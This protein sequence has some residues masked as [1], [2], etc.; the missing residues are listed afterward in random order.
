VNNKEPLISIVSTVYKSKSYLNEFLSTCI[1]ALNNIACA[2]YEIIFVN[3][4]SP[5]DS[6]EYLIEKKKEIPKIQILDL[7]RN[8]GHH[9]AAVAGL[10]HS[11]GKYV[12]L[13][14]CDLEVSP[15]I[16]VRFYH[17]LNSE[18]VDVVYGYQVERKGRYLERFFGG[19]FWK[20][21]KY[22]S[23]ID[24]PEN[25][26]TERLMTR[27]YVEQL[28]RLGDRNLFLGGMMYWTGFNQIG[29]AVSKGLRK[30]KSTYTAIKRLRLLIEAITS[31]T[32][33]PLKLLFYFGSIVTAISFSWG[34]FLAISK[35]L[36]PENYLS[37]YVSLILV[38]SFFSGIIEM[39]LGLLGLYLGK[40]FKQVQS[41]PLFIVKDIY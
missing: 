34:A 40:I 27:R 5:D 15:E 32:S 26:V 19:I 24:I 16:L 17:L 36:N 9:Y 2:D 10:H 37:G 31:F 35:I 7:S 1:A 11:R 20:A 33:F 25:I 39:S 3:D 14:D 29:V 22:F 13:A 6:L 23:D 38:I 12:F 28:L 4:G 18:N 41:R 21:L 30:G 8:F